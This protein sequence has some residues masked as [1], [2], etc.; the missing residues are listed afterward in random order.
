M[1]KLKFSLED[2]EALSHWR[3]YH[4]HPQ[5][6]LKMEVVYLRSQK[7]ENNQIQR[8]CGISKASNLSLSA[9][10]SSGWSGAT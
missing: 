2:L 8:L 10:V 1:L 3:F 6:Q 5:V 9:R 4:P 7:L